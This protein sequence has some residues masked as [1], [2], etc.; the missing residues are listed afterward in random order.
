MGRSEVLSLGVRVGMFEEVCIRL[1]LITESSSAARFRV[2]V[3]A[4]EGM[5]L[6]WLVSLESLACSSIFWISV[7]GLRLIMS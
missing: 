4:N 3:T 5:E 7:T 1:T 2:T 6:D